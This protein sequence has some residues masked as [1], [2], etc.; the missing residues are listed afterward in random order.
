M[1]YESAMRYKENDVTAP[2]AWVSL[3][4]VFLSAVI[5]IAAA[6]IALNL[7]PKRSDF[8]A[9]EKVAAETYNQYSLRLEAIKKECLNELN[10]ITSED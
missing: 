6:K 9:V 5:I 10:A 4:G 1:S 7:Y 8:L 2:R 3:L